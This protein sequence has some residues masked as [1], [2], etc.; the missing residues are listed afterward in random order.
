MM[1]VDCAKSDF[2][3]VLSETENAERKTTRTVIPQR[4]APPRSKQRGGGTSKRVRRGRATR[5]QRDD[6]QHEAAQAQ[7][8]HEAPHAEE[9][10]HEAAA[11]D[12]AC[13]ARPGRA[14]GGLHHLKDE[15]EDPHT[16]VSI[17]G[18]D[19]DCEVAASPTSPS[20]L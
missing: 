14:G 4:P 9:E 3:W 13:W 19:R 12:R 18:G 15:L 16:T 5:H 6:E 7:Y 10:G 11:D 20:E 2:V 1:V 8:E 17:S